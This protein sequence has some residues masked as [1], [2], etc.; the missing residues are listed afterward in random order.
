MIEKDTVILDLDDY[1]ELI[2]EIFLLEK[3]DDTKEITDKV[4]YLSEEKI[5]ELFEI[6]EDLK[7]VVK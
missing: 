4:C 7:I 6:D 3:I 2:K 5:R 1:N